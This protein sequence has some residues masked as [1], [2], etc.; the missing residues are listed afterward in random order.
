M[1]SACPFIEYVELGM[2]DR[3]AKTPFVW[4]TDDDKKL[5]K[6]E[7]SQTIVHLVQ[8][9]RKNWR[10]LQYLAGLDVEKLDADHHAEVEAL[11]RQYK[12]AAEARESSIDSIA[13]AMSELAASSKAPSF[14]APPSGSVAVGATTHLISARPRAGSGR[15]GQRIGAGV[16]SPTRTSPKCTNCKTCYQEIPELFEK[17]RIVVDGAAKEVGH[18]I[19]GALDA[20]QGHAGTEGQDRSRRRQLRRGDHP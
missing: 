17:T 1:R 15:E 8:E 20:H 2:A 19:P 14:S 16:R 12:E 9:R 10:T 13:R 5:I 4:S 7:A 3:A 11:K 18:L 6:V